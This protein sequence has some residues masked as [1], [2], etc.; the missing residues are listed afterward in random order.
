MFT[1]D[2]EISANTSEGAPRELPVFLKHGVITRVNIVFPPGCAGLAHLQVF[3]NGHQVWPENEGG[4]FRGD[5]E[6]VTFQCYYPLLYEPFGLRLVGWNEDDSYPH[7]PMVRFEVLPEELVRPPRE[8]LG[9]LQRLGKL[10]F[11]A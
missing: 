9:I 10:F 3:D 1:Y 2:L 6:V 7:T 8:E 4:S 11:G 5:S